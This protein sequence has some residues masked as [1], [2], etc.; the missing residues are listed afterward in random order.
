M[1]KTQFWVFTGG[2]CC[3]IYFFL[4]WIGKIWTDSKKVGKILTK[5]PQEILPQIFNPFK[6]PTMRWSTY[7]F[8]QR[9]TDQFPN[10]HR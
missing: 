1:P 6:P 9:L 2:K 10:Q 4:N 7:L 8:I 5:L 3:F